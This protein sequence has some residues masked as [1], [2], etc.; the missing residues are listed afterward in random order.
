MSLKDAI[1]KFSDSVADLTNLEVTTY[2]GKLEQVVDATT[3]QLKWDEFK[4]SNGKL[5]L[6]AA[7]LVRP[8]Q[9]TVNFRAGEIEHGDLKALTDLHVAA[10]ESAQNG[11]LAMTKMFSGL[12]P[13]GLGTP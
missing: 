6:V 9:D 13:T 12:L 11:R 5:V 1:K 4:P 8:N 2:T 3:G 10:V 7:T